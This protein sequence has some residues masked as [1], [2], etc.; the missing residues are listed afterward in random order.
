M[1][2]MPPVISAFFPPTCPLIPLLNLSLG[3]V[4]SVQTD[5]LALT[6][7]LRRPMGRIALKRTLEEGS[8]FSNPDPERQPLHFP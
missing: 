7:M 5:S 2:L 4:A 3:V 8:L 1:P 6:S